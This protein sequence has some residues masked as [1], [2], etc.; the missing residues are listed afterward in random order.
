MRD[1]ILEDV[2]VDKEQ[3][4]TARYKPQWAALQPSHPID[5]TYGSAN[6]ERRESEGDE[7]T[8]DKYIPTRARTHPRYL[9]HYTTHHRLLHSAHS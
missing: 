1:E 2:T 7:L 8:L 3:K 6:E 4:A 5:Y 9:Y